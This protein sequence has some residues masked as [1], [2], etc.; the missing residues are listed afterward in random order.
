[1]IDPAGQKLSNQHIMSE[2]KTAVT[3]E[4]LIE[5]KEKLACHILP[6][7]T[8]SAADTGTAA[9][10]TAM[11]ATGQRDFIDSTGRVLLTQMTTAGG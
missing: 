3:E 5:A 4:K 7:G 11:S 1:M 6:P 9:T 10:Q 2:N 8:H